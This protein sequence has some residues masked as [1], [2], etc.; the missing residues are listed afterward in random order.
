MDLRSLSDQDL[1][2]LLLPL[3]YGEQQRRLDQGEDVAFTYSFEE[4]DVYHVKVSKKTGQL[5]LSAHLVK[6]T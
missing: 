5:K 2:R 1:E 4:G 3:L 6:V